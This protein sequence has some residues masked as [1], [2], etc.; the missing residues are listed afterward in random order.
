MNNRNNLIM[1]D[2]I[3]YFKVKNIPQ[4]IVITDYIKHE[5]INSYNIEES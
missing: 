2:D 3:L 5:T 1:L 4:R